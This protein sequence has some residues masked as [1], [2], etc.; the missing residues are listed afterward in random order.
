MGSRR[1][2]LAVVAA[3]MIIAGVVL[4]PAVAAS[5]AD[6]DGSGTEITVTVGPSDGSDAGGGTGTGTGGG[7]GTGSSD[8]PEAT[9]PNPAPSPTPIADTF[10]LGGIFGIGG[11]GSD[12]GW[13]ANPFAGTIHVQ[14]SVKNTS[15][16]ALTGSTSFWVDGPLGNKL[17]ET[18]TFDV[19]DLRP[20]ETRVVGAAL[21]GIGQ[22]TFVTAHA[23]FTPPRVV[24]G[25][26]L[27]PVTRDLFMFVM[28][29]FLAFGL[30][31]VTATVLVLLRF[32]M[33]R[34]A[35]IGSPA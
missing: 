17:G 6:G 20:G 33:F 19:A 15:E 23:T 11:L 27:A 21:P 35:A 16:H 25:V 10:D 30:L 7:P 32:R 9:D 34:A 29:W 1:A 2:P 22:W 4:A 31:A 5:A 12:Y 18:Q 24:D 26:K 28:P 3:A 13:S 14:L 8:S